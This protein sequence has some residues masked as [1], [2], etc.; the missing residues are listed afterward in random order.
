MVGGEEMTDKLRGVEVLEGLVS[1]E[2]MT[3]KLQGVEV[4]EGSTV[5]IVVRFGSDSDLLNPISLISKDKFP[6]L[7][8]FNFRILKWCRIKKTII[9]PR[10]DPTM[11]DRDM[12]KKIKKKKISI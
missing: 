3:D 6:S 8:C 5:V 12:A 7:T 10:P 2:E 11:I 4:L 9:K 1:G